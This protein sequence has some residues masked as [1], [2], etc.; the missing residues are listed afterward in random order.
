MSSSPSSPPDG[1]PPEHGLLFRA[2]TYIPIVGSLLWTMDERHSCGRS[3]A[4]S[5]VL[6]KRFFRSNATALLVHHR[7]WHAATSSPSSSS[8]SSSSLPRAVVYIIHGM[9][10]YCGRYEHVAEILTAAGFEVVALDHQGCGESEGDR[11]YVRSFDDYVS[12]VLQLVTEVQPAPEGVP[13]FL[14]GHSMGG[15][16]ALTVAHKSPELWTGLCLS[17][18]ALIVDPNLDTAL[19]RFLV[20]AISSILPKM[21]VQKLNVKNLNSDPQAVAQYERDPS[22]YHGAIRVR[23]GFEM[24]RAME[25]AFTWAPELKV[26]LLICHGDADTT[27]SILGSRKL[28]EE[29]TGISD[30][31]LKEYPGLFH[32]IFNEVPAGP[33]IVKEVAQWIADHIGTAPATK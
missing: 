19:N 18:P 23:V 26:P 17:A 22:M 14:L 6:M 12:D 4:P 28:M 33:G 9:G 30:K 11:A 31:T 8:S 21:E 5:V 10:E 3:A 15:L 27:C 32:E 20:R 13:R 7:R 16:I 1:P 24:M 2:A 25:A 29:A